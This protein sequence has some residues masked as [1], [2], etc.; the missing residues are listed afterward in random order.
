MS[1]H[2]ELGGP[3]VLGAVHAQR[4]KR[5]PARK[6]LQSEYETRN[7]EW[8]R[9]GD[10]ET[11]LS[12]SIRSH[13]CREEEV[14]LLCSDSLSGTSEC[15]MAPS[16]RAQFSPLHVLCLQPLWLAVLRD[17]LSLPTNRRLLML[18]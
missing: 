15:P 13:T 11:V 16:P 10:K 17:G 14:S 12:S 9:P 4:E 6:E 5:G 1:G 18:C 7:N 3:V 2:P 8:R